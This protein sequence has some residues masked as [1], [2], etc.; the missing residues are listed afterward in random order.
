MLA[1][2]AKVMFKM[3]ALL[4]ENIDGFIFNFPASSASFA[5]ESDVF[6]GQKMVGDPC[7]HEDSFPTFLIGD[8]QFAPVHIECICANSKRELSGPAISPEVMVFPIPNTNFLGLYPINLFKQS[9]LF[10]KG[11]MRIWFTDKDKILLRDFS[12]LLA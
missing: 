6:G 3:I 10:I 5:D 11:F 1:P 8:V 7:I 4:F 9:N 12:N 2:M